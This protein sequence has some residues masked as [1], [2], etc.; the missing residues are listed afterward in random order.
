ML[1]AFKVKHDFRRRTND[2][3]TCSIFIRTKFLLIGFMLGVVTCLLTICIQHFLYV[4][5]F[6]FLSIFFPFFV[7][8]S[9][10]RNTLFRLTYVHIFIHLGLLFTKRSY[11][12]IMM[13]YNLSISC[14]TKI[15]IYFI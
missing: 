11:N 13:T 7:F 14:S 4:I 8:I 3:L 12:N 1:L 6:N 2:K 10:N 15:I 5:P 9:L